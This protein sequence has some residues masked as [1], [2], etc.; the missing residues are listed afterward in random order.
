[1]TDIDNTPATDNN[2]PTSDTTPV[3]APEAAAVKVARKPGLPRTCK[4][5]VTGATK[6]VR[7]EVLDK[8]VARYG[9][10][11][12]LEASYVCT[13]S[14]Q[15]LR[16]GKSVDQIRAEYK[17]AHA[18]AVIPTVDVPQA[19]IDEIMKKVAKKS[20]DTTPTAAGDVTATAAGDTT[21]VAASASKKS[22]KKSHKVTDAAPAADAP[23]ADAAPVTEEPTAS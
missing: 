3:T 5:I 6:M 17:A 9:S 12:A 7:P 22:A 13:E 21:P 4:C 11:A 1:M 16:E 23:V 20:E 2:T 19:V 10:V 8:R 18:D 14:K 15:A